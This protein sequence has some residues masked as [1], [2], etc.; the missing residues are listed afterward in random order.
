MKFVLQFEGCLRE[1]AQAK[2]LSVNLIRCRRFV[3]KFQ[4]VFNV[5]VI[6]YEYS[7]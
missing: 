2:P 6:L 1:P 7:F 5:E 3:T 4:F